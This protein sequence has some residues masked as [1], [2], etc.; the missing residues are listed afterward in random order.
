[1]TVRSNGKLLLTGEYFVLDGAVALAIPSKYGQALTVE[2][3]Q[4]KAATLHWQS[5]TQD[6]EI[7]FAA[8]YSTTNW[9]VQDTTDEAIS[10]KLRNILKG[11]Q[12]L[13][14]SFLAEAA[15]LRVQT[16]LEFPR[17]WGLG[18]SSTLINNVAKWATVDPFELQFQ[19][20]GGSG[21]DI[22]CAAHDTPILYQKLDDQ[23]YVT[24][25]MFEPPF[26]DHLYFVYLGQKQNSREGIARYRA[27]VKYNLNMVEQI[28]QLTM[29]IKNSTEITDFQHLLQ[30]HEEI[31]AQAVELPKVQDLYFS[32]FFGTIKSLGA[33]G[34]D[35]VL[36][37][38]SHNTDETFAYFQ[39]KGFTTIVPYRKMV[40]AIDSYQRT[41]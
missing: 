25:T 24:E 18:T 8:I 23:P 14:P 32:D 40:K 6:R 9:Q 7:W 22:A 15:D 3:L 30:E 39:S 10:N 19:N 28:S 1:M 31:V 13:N 33:W 17:N 36:A 34:G 35:F 4:T 16:S 2:K 20:F 11:A 41:I 21:Y 38:S 26:V 27:K 12:Q 29:A 37:A 5:I